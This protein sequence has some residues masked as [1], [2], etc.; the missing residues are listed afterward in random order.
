MD[1]RKTLTHGT[2]PNTLTVDLEAVAR[3]ATAALDHLVWDGCSAPGSP[4]CPVCCEPC[5]AIKRLLDDGILDR[6]LVHDPSVSGSSWWATDHCGNAG[7]DRE[8]LA[9]CWRP[10]GGVCE[11]A[12]EADRG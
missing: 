9:R 10:S 6:L 5:A 12:R 3:L 8:W 11:W 4:C 2:G 7:V 1:D